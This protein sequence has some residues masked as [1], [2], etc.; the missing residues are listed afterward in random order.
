VVARKNVQMPEKVGIYMN[1]RPSELPDV[2]FMGSS[3]PCLGFSPSTAETILHQHGMPL[4][5]MNLSIVAS[6]FDLNVLVLKNVILPRQTPRMIIYGVSE[7]DILGLGESDGHYDSIKRLPY[8]HSLARWDDWKTVA[9]TKVKNLFPFFVG[10]LFPL[11]RDRQLVFDSFDVLSGRYPS[12]LLLPAGRDFVP[13]TNARDPKETW[14]EDVGYRKI[15]PG[16][17]LKISWSR[18]MHALASICRKNDIK[19]VLVH[20]PVNQQFQKYW[21]NAARLREYEKVMS[22]VVAFEGLPFIDYY[23]AC[24]AVIPESDF[25]DTGHLQLRGAEH[26]TTLVMNELLDNSGR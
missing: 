14:Q 20:M 17:N 19:L 2:L 11:F 6:T 24:P 8:T 25:W 23:S 15:L 12:N 1:M 26:L 21:K 10:Q 3:R 9:G 16:Y 18:D 7:F 13:R 22:D 5:V 4:R